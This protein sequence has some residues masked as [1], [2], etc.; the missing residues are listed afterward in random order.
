MATV[1]T[2]LATRTGGA[3]RRDNRG[4]GCHAGVVAKYDA[5]FKRL[6]ADPDSVATLTFDEIEALVG[7]L[8]SAAL[9]RRQWWSNDAG[10]GQVQATAWLNAG[11]E[12]EHV[13][14]SARRVR[15]GPAQWRRGA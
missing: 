12:I 10:A 3:E 5:L 8:P 11:R 6:C 7:A 15:F 13:D 4:S 2:A 9:T 14:L 1:R